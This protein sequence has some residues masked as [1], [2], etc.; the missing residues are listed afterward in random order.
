M[1]NIVYT[2]GEALI[3]F[4]TLEKREAL[5]EAPNFQAVPSGVPANGVAVVAKQ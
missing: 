4:V 1:A 3:D 2:I 5:Y